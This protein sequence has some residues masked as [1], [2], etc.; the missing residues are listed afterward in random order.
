[1]KSWLRKVTIRSY[2]STTHLDGNLRL[3]QI[4]LVL[5]ITTGI[6][7]CSTFR[8]P[9]VHRINIQQ[10]NVVTQQM[11]DRLK[12]GMTKAQVRFVLGNPVVEDSL[13]SEQWDYIH[14]LQVRGGDIVRRSLI[15][16]FREDRLSHFEGDYLP[17][18]AA[19]SGE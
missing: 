6:A 10:G 11:L 5:G 18:E 16:H 15:L 7:A 9:G 13:Q 1:M 17:S 4:I 2:D 3:L 12:P 19:S 14:S 8:F